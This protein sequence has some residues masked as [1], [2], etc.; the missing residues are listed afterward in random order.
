[1]QTPCP[2]VVPLQTPDPGVFFSGMARSHRSPGIFSSFL[3]PK[4]SPFSLP[5]TRKFTLFHF[6]RRELI[7]LSC[8]LQPTPTT[9]QMFLSSSRRM[10]S[11]HVSM[12][13]SSRVL[14]RVSS[15]FLSLQGAAALDKHSG[16]HRSLH[17][18]IPTNI[19]HGT[20]KFPER[21][22]D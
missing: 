21:S 15:L 17:T 22:S 3:L 11:S 7:P 12:Q 5:F 18:W 20:Y 2:H 13:G 10:L 14:L 8:G 4:E 1:M 6:T 9:L 19:P 16:D